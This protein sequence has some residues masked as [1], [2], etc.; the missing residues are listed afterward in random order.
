MTSMR[1]EIALVTGSTSGIGLAIA[2]ALAASG[3]D[4]VFH[5]PGDLAPIQALADETAQVH[6]VRTHA[7]A[8]DLRQPHSIRTAIDDVVTHFGPI[9]ILVNNAGVQHVASIVNFPEEQWDALLA[10]NLSAAFHATK[11]VLPGMITRRHGRIVNIASAH[12]LVASVD[13]SA[14]V[15]AKHG[16]VGFT[17]VAALETARTGVTVNAIC[18]GWVETPLVMAQVERR[19]RERGIDIG[20]ATESLVGE[21]HPTG[22]FIR[23]N[24]IAALVVF[25]C[26]EHGEGM[27]GEII[28]MDGGWT[29]Q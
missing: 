5:G 14:Y 10:V 29:A 11:A 20:A 17:K 22:R 1:R 19:A 16:L 8:A 2:R 9:D 24:S 3:R 15:A 26:S 4:V 13:K 7:I 23:P 25:L 12:G 27:T 28:S 21:K 6:N 18:P